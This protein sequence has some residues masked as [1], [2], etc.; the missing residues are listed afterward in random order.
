MTPP[1]TKELIIRLLFGYPILNWGN[2][3][4]AASLVEDGLG[5]VPYRSVIHVLQV[6]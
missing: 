1:C 6:I 4:V 2:R 3:V 5:G